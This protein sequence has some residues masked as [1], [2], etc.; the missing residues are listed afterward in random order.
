M[1]D[2]WA[3]DLWSIVGVALIGLMAGLLGGMLGVGGSV[4]MIPGLVLMFGI[5]D[6]HLFQASAMIV[7]VAVAGP[8]AWKHYQAGGTVRMVLIWMLPFAIVFVLL[9]VWVSNLWFFAGPEGA[10]WLGRLLAV[11]LLYVVAAN[12]RK[13]LDSA[14]VVAK[15]EASLPTHMPRVE[16]K[17]AGVGSGMGMLAGLLGIGGGALAVPMQQ[18]LIKLPLRNCIA[19]SSVVMVCSALVG[20]VMKNATL[21]QHGDY[22]VWSGLQLALFLIPTAIIGARLGA[23][24]TYILPLRAIRIVF[25][26]LMLVASWKM[27]S[28]PWPSW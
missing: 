3:F 18:T 6:E 22:S 2:P 9:G 26:G 8:A 5:Q 21:E 17:S 16:V 14:A 23:S 11:F 25:I 19:N 1:I 28:L 15:Q 13:L 27:A 4:I 7:N 10:V 24:L 20:A 12:V